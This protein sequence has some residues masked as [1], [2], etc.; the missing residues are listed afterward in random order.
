MGENLECA[1]LAGGALVKFYY[2][3]VGVV[4]FEIVFAMGKYTHRWI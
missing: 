1:P 3:P 4:K 2:V